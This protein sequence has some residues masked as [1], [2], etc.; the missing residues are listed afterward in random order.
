MRYPLFIDPELAPNTDF[1]AQVMHVSNGDNQEWDTTSGTTSQGSGVTE[2]GDCG[3]SSCIWD[4]PNGAAQGYT[5]RDYFRFATTDLE[6]RASQTATVYQVNFDVTEEGNSNGCT[7]QPSDVYST[8]GGISASTAWGGPQGSK[9]AEASSNKGGSSSC[10]AGGVDFASTAS[11]NSA[12]KTTL[13]AIATAGDSTV[14]LELRADSETQE[15]QYKTYK[16][17]PSLSVYFNFAPLTPTALSVQNQVTCDSSVT[18]TSLTKPKLFAT[19]TDN[20][21]APLKI[22]LNY[23]LQT[24]AGV[25]A[26][27]TL[28]SPNGASGSAQSTTPPTALTSGTA[29]QFKVSAT[30]NVTDGPSTNRTGPASAF[31]PFTVLTPPAVA[32]TIS[33]FDYPQGQWGQQQGAPGEFTVGTGGAS[34]IAGFAYSFDGGAG[35]EPVPSTTDCNYGNQGGLGTSVDSNGDGGG[36]TSGELALVQGSTAQ[37]QIPK[38]VTTGPH[39]LFV[40]S[41]DKAHNVSGET[42]YT[43][44]VAPDFQATSQPVTYINGNS[45]VAGATGTNASLISTQANCCGLTWRGGGQL[46]FNGTALGQTFTVT[47]TVPDAGWWQLGADLTKSFDYGQAQ[48]DLDQAT[49]DINLASTATVPYDGYSA[50]VSLHYL[51]LGTQDLSAGSHTLTFTIT[52]QTTG[53]SG[54]KTGINYLT[55]SPTNRYEGESLPHSTPTA[56]TLAPQSFAGRPGRATA[57]SCWR[58]ARPERNTRSASTRR[59][60]PTTRSAS[61]SPQPTTT[62]PCES[63]STRR[64]PTSTSTAPR[65][66]RLTSTA[67]PCRRPTCSS[68]ACT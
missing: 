30:N 38:S 41:F 51:D 58:T 57:S 20:N 49:A 66:A 35:S 23:T 19:G 54:F 65:R 39:T 9:I 4:T 1:Y 62:A 48:V 37:I 14:T 34:N 68:A 12:L 3:Y 7:S 44:Y 11:G 33:S 22:T 61:T 25:A 2:V 40:V 10:P 52:G 6:K 60:S 55:L 18:Y 63:T 47:I 46:L 27:G 50:K 17:N 56:G 59:S 5:D 31:Y 24:S 28:A 26:S 42:A 32:P 29:Y 13:Q 16:D 36:S 43:F 21:P 45:L 53:S 15:L 8:T 64:P 67:S